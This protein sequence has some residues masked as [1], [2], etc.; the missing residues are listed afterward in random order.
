MQNRKMKQQFIIDSER[1]AFYAKKMIDN[2]PTDGSMVV[3]I[4]KENRTLKNNAQ[5]WPILAAFADQ[6]LWP[7]NGQ[8]VKMDADEWKDVLS[9][10]Y[11]QETVRLAMGLDG[12]IVMLGKRTSKF[13]KSQWPEWIAFLESVASNRGVKIP[14]GK[15][16]A[17]SMGIE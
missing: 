3:T 10:A 7:V 1:S 2:L 16:M 17:E 8:M 12:G 15:A 4:Q 13:T 5:Q 9:S 14:I 11:H 6:L